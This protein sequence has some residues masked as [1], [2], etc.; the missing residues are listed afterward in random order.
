MY[1]KNLSDLKKADVAPML[2]MMH[3]HEKYV[4]TM[5]MDTLCWVTR[6]DVVWVEKYN[7]HTG[8]NSGM[9]NMFKPRSI[10]FHMKF[11]VYRA[12]EPVVSVVN[13]KAQLISHPRI[14]NQ[15]CIDCA[16]DTI[17]ESE[18]NIFWREHSRERLTRQILRFAALNE[19]QI[20]LCLTA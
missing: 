11:M 1:A 7:H 6:K 9:D 19:W 17:A 12:R 15:W 20:N 8:W 14:T 4:F 5:H 18:Q 3:I 10:L 13:Q 16:A 2:I